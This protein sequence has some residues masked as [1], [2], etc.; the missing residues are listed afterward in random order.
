MV[1]G[2]GN[3][4]DYER[5][6]RGHLVVTLCADDNRIKL[7]AI[8]NVDNLFILFLSFF[9]CFFLFFPLWL[10]LNSYIFIHPFHHSI[11]IFFL[12]LLS[13][14]FVLVFIFHFSYSFI[15]VSISYLFLINSSYIFSFLL[16]FYSCFSFY[17][18]SSNNFFHSSFLSNH[19][20]V[21]NFNKKLSNTNQQNSIFHSKAKLCHSQCRSR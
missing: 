17:F 13:Y 19:Q 21:A 12:F 15:F 10:V 9:P 18:Y 1:W 14:Y 8:F 7:P 2:I 4:L 6:I 5:L 11:I 3:R 16:L 20:Y